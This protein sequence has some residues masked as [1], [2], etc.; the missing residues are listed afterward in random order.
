MTAAFAAAANYR[1]KEKKKMCRNMAVCVG[2]GREAA[3]SRRHA[4]SSL[5]TD[6]EKW[7]WKIRKVAD[8]KKKRSPVM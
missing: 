5:C 8:G 7:R 3:S 1:K 4:R 2:P 6:G